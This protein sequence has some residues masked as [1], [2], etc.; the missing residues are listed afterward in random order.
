MH[1]SFE[2]GEYYLWVM[3]SIIT[4]LLKPSDFNRGRGI[5]LFDSIETFEKLL[6]E[7]KEGV[8]EYTIQP[9]DQNKCKIK[10]HEFVLQKYI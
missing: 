1:P 7:M 3:Y 4:K 8:S 6:L 9:D 2:N 5:Q 10:S